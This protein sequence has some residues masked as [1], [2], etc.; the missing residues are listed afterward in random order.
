MNA[1][2]TTARRIIKARRAASKA[3]KQG[4]HTLKSHC[5]KAGIEETVADAV[6]GALRP[7]AKG[8]GCTSYMVRKSAAGVVPV[9]GGKRYSKADVLAAAAAYR[10]RVATYKDARD[11][12]LS[13]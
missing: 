3:H 7:K 13:Y 1:T 5:I 10:P 4:L 8:L 2:A 9:R 6:A 12:L 11:L